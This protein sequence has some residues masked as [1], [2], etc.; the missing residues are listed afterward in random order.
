[1]KVFSAST[2]PALLAA[3]LLLSGCSSLSQPDAPAAPAKPPTSSE[4][5]S[6]ADTPVT[7]GRFQQDTLYEL[8]SAEIAG[9]RNRFD[10][11]LDNYLRQARSTRDAGISE[12]AL[13]V[14]EFLGNEPA[15]LEMARLWVEV[16]PQDP[17]ALR[18]AAIHLARTGRHEQAMDTMQRALELHGETHF[19]FLALAAADTDATT[20]NAL[21]DSLERMNDRF[22]DNTQLVFARALLLQQANRN[23]EALALLEE[24]PHTDEAP[25]AILLHSRLVAEQ[26]IEEATEILYRGLESFPDDTRLRLM[27]A[28][29]LVSEGNFA[30]ARTQYAK[31]ARDNPDEPDLQ[32]SLGLIELELGQASDAVI[33][34]QNTLQLAPG[35]NTARYHLGNA[36]LAA[37]RPDDALLT[38]QSIDS[39]TELLTSRVQMARLL[40]EQDRIAALQAQLQQDRDQHPQHG[41][42][43][44]QIEIEALLPNHP[45]LAI[46]QANT[47][48]Q[49]YPNDSNLLY[50]RA[51]LHEM[52]GNPRGLEEDL[53]NIIAREPDNAMALN[54]LGYTLADRNERLDE[55]LALIKR[56]AALDPSDPAIQ[57]SLGWVYYRLGDLDRAEALL[58]DAYAAY[59]DQ[60]VAA[61]LGEVLWRQGKEREARKIWREAL[62]HSP[63]SQ[64]IPATRDRLEAE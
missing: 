63:D 19:D 2:L 13:R 57:D 47:A 61:H 60:E 40:L 8:L 7:Y 45:E 54:A 11:A 10:L 44:F 25:P 3:G 12:R 26:D 39:G 35:N 46:Q 29:T 31:L 43:L 6:T 59:P 1:M 36:Y 50:S 21:L 27:L 9:Q 49:A 41:L 23:A 18:S 64:L 38:W 17:E 51:M 15:A 53:G 4:T 32:L 37:D 28:R 52:L 56:A 24:H 14:A 20:R 22:P 16:A 62:E 30:D 55:A 48:L 58:R 42:A 33:H 34:L 5:D